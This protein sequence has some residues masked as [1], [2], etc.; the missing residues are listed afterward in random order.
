MKYKRQTDVQTVVDLG[1]ISED[2]GF[3]EFALE[4]LH[5]RAT[6][7]VLKNQVGSKNYE[8]NNNLVK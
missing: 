3:A 2:L 1:G 7:L 4:N 8:R 6:Y 5:I